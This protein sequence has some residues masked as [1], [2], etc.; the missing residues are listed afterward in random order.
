MSPSNP[1]VK[2]EVSLNGII[3]GGKPET[4]Y[5]KRPIYF[6]RTEKT[7]CFMR[8]EMALGIDI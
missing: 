4:N 7:E 6:F 2:V 5:L 8:E 3:E 1:L